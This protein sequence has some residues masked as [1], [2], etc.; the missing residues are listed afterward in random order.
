MRHWMAVGLAAFE[1]LLTGNTATGRYCHGDTP[2][3][4]DA[5]LVPQVYNALRWKLPLDDY[6]TIRRIHAACSELDA[7]RR[8]AP[9]VQP[10]AM[11]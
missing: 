9:E 1:A 10:D 5:C 8:A 4:A 3:L 7:F 2:G 11:A 6:P